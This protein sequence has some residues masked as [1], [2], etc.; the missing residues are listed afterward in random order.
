MRQILLATLLA[1]FLFL[2][3]ASAQAPPQEPAAVTLL[4]R[5]LGAEVQFTYDRVTATDIAGSALLSGAVLRKGTEVVRIT[6]ARLEGLSETGVARLSLRGIAVTGELPLT[7][8]RLDLEGLTIRPPAAGQ[9]FLPENVSF[10]VFRMEGW[11][12][13]GDVPVNLG[14]LTVEGFGPGR[15]GQASLTALEVTTPSMLIADRLTIARIAYAGFDM[16]DVLTAVIAG[17]APGRTPG[18]SSMEIEGVALSQGGAAVARLSALSLRGEILAG[19]PHIGSFALRGLELLPSPLIAGWMQRLGYERLGADIRLDASHDVA[20]Q[21]LEFSE[22]ALELRDVGELHLA[23]RADRVPEGMDAT[24]ATSARLVSARLR[25]VD[26]SLFQRWL[27]TEAVAQGTPE[28]QM[29]DTMIQQAAALLPG[30]GFAEAR[31]ALTRFL[32]GEATVLELAA[33]PRVPMPFSQPTDKPPTNMEGW[34]N[35]FGL[36]LTAR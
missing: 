14:A 26:R 23:F 24:N 36:T 9:E 4:R 19:R 13:A 8:D 7:L 32:R 31:A 2:T 27:R 34:R 12:S 16:N 20:A 18:R 1:P 29:R 5:L 35:M 3:P 10:D 17:R 25:Y 22:V 11:R 33:N 28:R 15:T 30:A 6:E 21:I